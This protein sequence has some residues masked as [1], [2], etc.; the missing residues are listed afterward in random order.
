ME[1]QFFEQALRGARDTRLFAAEG[2]IRHRAAGIFTSLFGAQRAVVVADRNTY[3]VAGRDVQA[4]LGSEAFVFGPHVYADDRCV[5]ELQAALQPLDAIAVAVGS[6]TINDLTKLVSHR[7]GRPYM[8]VATAASMDGYAAFGASITKDG[9]KQTMECGGPRGVLADLD[10]IARAPEGMNAWG[11]ADLLAKVVAGA[12]WI[13]AEAAGDEPIHAVAWEM[14]HRNLRSWVGSP[15]GIA[16]KDAAALRH[17]LSGLVMSGLAMQAAQSSRPASG[18]EHQFSHVWDMQH[19]TFNGEAP[20]HGFKVGIATLATLALYEELL[21]RDFREFDIEPAVRAWPSLESQ[22]AR[23]LEFFGPGALAARAI[24][25]TR[26]KYV[27]QEGLRAQLTRLRGNWPEIRARLVQQLMPFRQVR[28]MLRRA[29]CP[30][31]PEE[32]GI[33]RGR[34]RLTYEQCCY[35]RRRFTVLDFALRTGLLEPALDNLFGP[36]GPWA[37][38]S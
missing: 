5:E 25:E 4:S 27:S 8:I 32:I 15:E 18:A 11:Y 22:E 7:L 23:I 28:D 16:R 38:R 17:L 3:A 19:H 33:S 34:L 24:E 9:S 12:D 35:T 20:S 2:A 21:R 6:G 29:G 26:L 30:F 36:D 37:A 13:L 31:D 1:E 10:V 14:V